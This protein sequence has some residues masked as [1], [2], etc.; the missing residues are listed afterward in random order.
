ME[1]QPKRSI[2]VRIDQET[3]E[4][5]RQIAKQEYRTIS[6]QVFFWVRQRIQEQGKNQPSRKENKEPEKSD[7]SV[8]KG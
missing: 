2:S 4:R 7:S 3:Y 5:L 1:K 8:F 6:G